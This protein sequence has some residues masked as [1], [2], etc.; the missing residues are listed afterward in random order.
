MTKGGYSILGR[1]LRLEKAE[2]AEYYIALK[3]L[4]GRANERSSR[5]PQQE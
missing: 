4:L 5:E 2:W 1:A 3:G